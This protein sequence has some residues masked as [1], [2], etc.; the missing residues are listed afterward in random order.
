MYAKIP[1]GEAGGI[2]FGCFEAEQYGAEG[3]G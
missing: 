2:F 1:L 3:R